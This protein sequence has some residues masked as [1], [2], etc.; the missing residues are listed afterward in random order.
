MKNNYQILK[1]ELEFNQNYEIRNIE[2][3]KYQK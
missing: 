2:L 3:I 1:S